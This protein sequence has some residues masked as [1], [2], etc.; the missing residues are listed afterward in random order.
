[1]VG[2]RVFI[3]S[4]C[5]NTSL[6]VEKKKIFFSPHTWVMVYRIWYVLGVVRQSTVSLCSLGKA[7]WIETYCLK[8]ILNHYEHTLTRIRTQHPCT[9]NLIAN[10]SIVYRWKYSINFWESSVQCVIVGRLGL[11]A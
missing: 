1:M 2:R 8:W 7:N 3:F 9:K 6:F 5:L 10:H 4:S 11:N